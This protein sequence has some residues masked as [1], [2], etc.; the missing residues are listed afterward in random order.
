[1]SIKEIR[2][3]KKDLIENQYKYLG[4]KVVHSSRK[5]ERQLVE[6]SYDSKPITSEDLNHIR[7]QKK[8]KIHNG[9]H[10]TLILVMNQ[11]TQGFTQGSHTIIK[12]LCS[13]TNFRIWESHKNNLVRNFEGMVYGGRKVTWLILVGV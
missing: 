3:L 7:I 12:E 5:W 9:H 11:G 4:D 1:M 8:M 6:T 2:S 13:F 10:H